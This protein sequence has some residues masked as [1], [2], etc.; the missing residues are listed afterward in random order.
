MS[1]EHHPLSLEARS[2]R[3]RQDGKPTNNLAGLNQYGGR[4][5]SSDQIPTLIAALEGMLRQGLSRQQMLRDL[6]DKHN[7]PLS[8]TT[9]FRWLDRLQ[10]GTPRKPVHTDQQVG[11]AVL[12]VLND[13]ILHR[14]GVQ[15]V[16]Y[17]VQMSQGVTDA[18]RQYVRDFMRT[19]APYEVLSRTPG[20][21]KIH[22]TSLWSI[23]IAEEWSGDGFEKL[24]RE[25]FHPH[26][27]S[28]RPKVQEVRATFLFH[29]PTNING[30]EG[31]PLRLV[32]DRGSETIQVGAL[33]RAL[34]SQFAPNIEPDV[35]PPFLQVKSVY[36]I[37]I[38]RSWRGLFEDELEAIA[39]AW[40]AGV[41]A[42]IYRPHRRDE[43]YTARWVWARTVQ[44]KLDQYMF[45]KNNMKIRQQKRSHLPCGHSPDQMWFHPHEYNLDNCL[46]PVPDYIL[47]Q[48]I[49][50]YTPV[51]LF[52]FVPPHVGEFLEGVYSRFGRPILNIHSAWNVYQRMLTEVP[53]DIWEDE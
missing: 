25:S 27:T 36:N 13:D 23:G 22:K 46:V 18:K 51:G 53:A 7:M 10:L 9:L 47:D 3:G 14:W 20:Q 31:V 28:G 34:R 24:G 50:L 16:A 2:W 45:E 40:D 26:C 19:H 21:K 37:T 41:R 4:R 44:L 17:K 1:A 11:E 43:S 29:L 8:R 38:E 6:K 49:E 12:T 30:L 42:G 5:I 32:V 48:L 39:V 35:L 33:A 52:E 15:R